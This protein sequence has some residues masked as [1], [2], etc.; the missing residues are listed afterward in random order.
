MS[1]FVTII[2]GRSGDLAVARLIDPGGKEVNRMTFELSGEKLNVGLP[3]PQDAMGGVWVMSVE[4]AKTSGTIAFTVQT[5]ASETTRPPVPPVTPKAG[6]PS[7]TPIIRVGDGPLGI[8]VNPD[9]NFVYVANTISNTISVIDGKRNVVATIKVGNEPQAVAINANANI[10]YVVNYESNSVSV[11]DGSTNSVVKTIMVGDRP[12]SVAVNPSTGMIYITNIDSV[13]VIDGS[14][15]SVVKTIMEGDAPWNIAVNPSTNMIYVTRFIHDS[16]SVID[17]STNSVVKTIDVAHGTPGIDAHGPSG[18][19]LNPFT[20]MIYVTATVSDSVSVIDGTTNNV[21]MTM[22]VGYKPLGIAVNPSTNMIYVVNSRSNSLSVI[23]GKS[24]EEKKTVEERKDVSKTSK[25]PTT[26]E[27][28]RKVVGKSGIIFNVPQP[29]LEPAYVGKYYEY[30][31]CD[32]RPSSE[33]LCGGLIEQQ[34]NNPVGGVQPYT[35]QKETLLEIGGD[36]PFGLTLHPNGVLDGTPIKQDAGKTFKFKVCAIDNTRSFVCERTSLKVVESGE[37]GQIGEPPE[38]LI[39]GE[40]YESLTYKVTLKG[41]IKETVTTNALGSVAVSP[42]AIISSITYEGYADSKAVCD[43]PGLCT[44]GTDRGRGPL[45]ISG[46]AHSS[47]PSF[48]TAQYDASGE[49][50][51]DARGY[52]IIITFTCPNDSVVMPTI[53]GEM[54]VVVTYNEAHYSTGKPGVLVNLGPQFIPPPNEF[55]IYSGH[56]SCA[57]KSE[58]AQWATPHDIMGQGWLHAGLK[59]YGIHEMGDRSPGNGRFILF[60]GNGGSISGH[61]VDQSLNTEFSEDFTITVSLLSAEKAVQGPSSSEQKPT[62]PIEEVLP[63]PPTV[64]AEVRSG[65]DKSGEKGTLCN[66]DAHPSCKE[67]S[68]K[69]QEGDI[70]HTGESDYTVIG[71]DNGKTQIWFGPNQS[72]KVMKLSEDERILLIFEPPF[73]MRALVNTPTGVKTLF[74][75]CPEE[76]Q[77][78]DECSSVNLLLFWFLVTGTEFTLDQHQGKIPKL[79]VLEGDVQVWK[80]AD[81][82]VI[83]KAGTN[84]QLVLESDRSLV[85]S[86]IDPS[87][88]D[89]WWIKAAQLLQPEQTAPQPTPTQAPQPTKPGG[90]CLIATA[91]FGSELTPQVQFLRN[92]RDNHI[93]STAA[94]SSFMN[95]FNAWYY[96]FSPNVANAERENPVL[97]QMI[98]YAIYPLLGILTVAEKVYSV[99]NGETGAVTAGFV[100]SS[101]IGFVYLWP[102]AYG[103]GKVRRIKL[104]SNILIYTIVISFIGIIAGILISDPILLM[105]TTSAFVVTI[106]G[107]S[108]MISVKLINKLIS[109]GRRYLTD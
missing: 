51:K 55:S 71:L 102:I 36:I 12:S 63:P 13:S 84:E 54:F 47:G 107:I 43:Q 80:R 103:I 87:S 61:Y 49:C 92:F 85:P 53:E 9:T 95:V 83:A 60:D 18:I 24:V 10:I 7:V 70:I 100:T 3:L 2:G 68:G 11:I 21:V 20:N 99:F 98:K 14:T 37:A 82:G 75:V 109:K 81:Q 52:C 38:T 58:M 77:K 25:P 48:K 94:G 41:S 34:L 72:V 8:A 108:S 22:R 19:D 86:T 96:S 66:P 31:F 88:V 6:E 62:A 17:G 4:Y 29:E 56:E 59:D 101:M 91:A 45:K 26:G 67:L 105:I 64:P 35:F 46:T 28:E 42:G 76:V 23:D 32:P 40:K 16:V 104:S 90:G 78:A 50:V 57:S 106:L 73:Q 69:V 74:E 44:S 33:L 30:S 27:G 15:N 89:R 1:V 97:Q 93:L 5:S 39:P 79:T 65:T